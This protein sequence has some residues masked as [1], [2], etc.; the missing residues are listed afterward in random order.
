[1][2]QSICSHNQSIEFYFEM[3]EKIELLSANYDFFLK[4]NA[5]FLDFLNTYIKINFPLFLC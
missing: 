4:R 2:K 3:I 5:N 1:M